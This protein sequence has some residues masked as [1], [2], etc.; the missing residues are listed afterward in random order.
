MLGGERA[1]AGSSYKAGVR[2]PAL[3][4]KQGDV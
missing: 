4:V 2:L 3:G 1:S